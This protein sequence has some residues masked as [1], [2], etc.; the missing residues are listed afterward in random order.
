MGILRGTALD[1]FDC[2]W[3]KMLALRRRASVFFGLLFSSDWKMLRGQGGSEFLK[4]D[5]EDSEQRYGDWKRHSQR[6]GDPL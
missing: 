4:A 5:S 2:G 1:F 3:S 6:Y